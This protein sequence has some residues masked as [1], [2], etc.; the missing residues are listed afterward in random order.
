MALTVSISPAEV[1]PAK[2]KNKIVWGF[3]TDNYITDA[4]TNAAL[5][6]SFTGL[7]AAGNTFTLTWGSNTVVFTCAITPDDS[8]LQYPQAYDEGETLAQW[9]ARIVPY[10]TSNYLVGMDFTVAVDVAVDTMVL[11]TAR[12]VGTAYTMDSSDITGNIVED[13]HQDGTDIV[14]NDF[15]K[16][17]CIPYAVVAGVSTKCGEMSLTPD[18]DDET[19]FDVA[20]AIA[21]YLSSEKFFPED[22][23]TYAVKRANICLPYF[24]R[25][26]EKYGDPQT[27]KLL[28]TTAN[29]YALNGGIPYWK[30]LEIYS[31]FSTWWEKLEYSKQFLTFSPA[32]QRI[33]SSQMVKLYY[34]VIGVYII[35]TFTVKREI[36]FTDGTT[37]AGT[38]FTFS[39]SQYE[40]YELMVGYAQNAFA[41]IA[42]NA[43]KTIA[44]YTVW[45]IDSGNTI[46]S[47]IKTFTL[48]WNSY[49]HTRQFMYLNSLGGYDCVFFSGL[50]NDELAVMRDT[51][52]QFRPR[53]YDTAFRE[54]RQFNIEGSQ[55]Y[56]L[57]TGWLSATEKDF[58]N[59]ILLSDEVWEVEGETLFPVNILNDKIGMG[60]D[61]T[62]PAY[63]IDLD[64]E[65]SYADSVYTPEPDPDAGDFNDDYDD[66]F[67]N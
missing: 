45:V 54:K 55:R 7:G 12:N 43:G 14:Y 63:A 49:E 11:F 51:I 36:T 16:A 47:E 26:A 58:M 30:Q 31:Q 39:G 62:E 42:Q 37:D 34:L 2:K 20:E 38:M 40:V 9:V 53:E 22:G 19:I 44:S 10:F 4:G 32:N 21:P 6:L 3:T 5:L 52:V 28:T 33:I 13:S 48:D 23:A 25:Y 67:N 60:G 50:K 41:T 66:D 27:V 56:K 15:F 24:I 1:Q 57:N 18:V 35:E 61:D 59:E 17:L 29:F 46:V 8:G 64:I 65:R